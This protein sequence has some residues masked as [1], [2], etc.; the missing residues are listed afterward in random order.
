MGCP[1]SVPAGPSSDNSRKPPPTAGTRK[2]CRERTRSTPLPGSSGT[3]SARSIQASSPVPQEAGRRAIPRHHMNILI[4][5]TY[6]FTLSH[7]RRQTTSSPMHIHTKVASERVAPAAAQDVA[8][9]LLHT[10]VSSTDAHSN[11][12]G[13][14]CS[15]HDRVQYPPSRSSKHIDERH[16]S[17][18]LQASPRA[19]REAASQSPTAHSRGRQ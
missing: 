4:R 10:L 15:A 9:K 1:S 2:S 8:A 5:M 13:Q 14:A 7:D 12:L 17:P 6:L 11:P 16:D 19:S 18:S 3:P